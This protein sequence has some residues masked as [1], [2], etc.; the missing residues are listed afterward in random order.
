MKE[1]YKWRRLIKM[2]KHQWKHLYAYIGWNGLLL[3]LD[4]D[5]K[6]KSYNIELSLMWTR[7]NLNEDIKEVSRL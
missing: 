6:G 2:P 7:F 5:Y 3:S 1:R 4:F